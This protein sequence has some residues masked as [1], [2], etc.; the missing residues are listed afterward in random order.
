MSTQEREAM[1]RLAAHDNHTHQH[2]SPYLKPCGTRMVHDR[3]KKLM[4]ERT[5]IDFALSRHARSRQPITVEGLVAMGFTR[6]RY[7]LFHEATGLCCYESHGEIGNW[8]IGNIPIE[9]LNP[10]SMFDLD[11]LIERLS[12]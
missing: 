1:E 5:I 6:G 9:P 11:N 7:G 8:L 10:E 12:R 2:P 4:D 3:E